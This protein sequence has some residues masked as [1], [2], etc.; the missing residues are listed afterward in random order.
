MPGRLGL[1]AAG[2]REG[3]VGLHV[4]AT[5]RSISA[6]GDAGAPPG[7]RRASAGQRGWRPV[8]LEWRWRATTTAQRDGEVVWQALDDDPVFIRAQAG[9]ARLYRKFTPVEGES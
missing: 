2:H 5:L 8:A 9:K 7:R 3:S 4:G 1:T 6:C